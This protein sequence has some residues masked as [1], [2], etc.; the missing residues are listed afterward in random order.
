M[1]DTLTTA[2][3]YWPAIKSRK[4]AVIFLACIV[5]IVLVRISLNP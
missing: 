1:S 4:S 3:K 5:A 2:Q